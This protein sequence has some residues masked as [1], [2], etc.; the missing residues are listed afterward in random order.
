MLADLPGDALASVVASTAEP[1]LAVAAQR[2]GLQAV[3]LEADVVLRAWAQWAHLALKKV[4]AAQAEREWA[5][6][7][8]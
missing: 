8:L 1:Y 3:L 5:P 2:A 7:E 4:E 6:L